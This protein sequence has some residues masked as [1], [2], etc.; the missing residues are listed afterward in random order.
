MQSNLLVI[1]SLQSWPQ[2]FHYSMRLRK[3]RKQKCAAGDTHFMLFHNHQPPHVL[4]C[5]GV[6]HTALC[7]TKETIR[8]WHAWCVCFPL[9]MPGHPQHTTFQFLGVLLPVQTWL[10]KMDLSRLFSSSF[11]HLNLSTPQQ[12]AAKS[13]KGS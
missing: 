8:C 4:R 3:M 13:P 7:E 10:S 5:N 11:M 2:S 6:G 1:F 12:A 9:T